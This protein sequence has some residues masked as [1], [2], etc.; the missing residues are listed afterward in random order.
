MCYRE[1]GIS[2]LG[3]G[4]V[5]ELGVNVTGGSLCM[6]ARLRASLSSGAD[7]LWELEV[8]GRDALRVMQ[9]YQHL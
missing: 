9:L 4:Q 2:G 6:G 7:V 5:W 1:Q 8:S 3:V